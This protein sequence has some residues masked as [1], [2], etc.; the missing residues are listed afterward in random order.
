MTLIANVFPKLQTLKNMVRSMPK[1]S[2]FRAAVEK[3]HRKCAQ[4]LFKFEGELIY[5]IY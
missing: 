1:M 2:S 3:Q 5:H 4:T